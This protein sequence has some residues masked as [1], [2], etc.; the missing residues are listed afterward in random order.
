MKTTPLLITTI[1]IL[2]LAGGVWAFVATQ[3]N[4]ENTNGANVNTKEEDAMMEK[5]ENSNSSS[6]NAN[7]NTNTS[8]NTNQTSAAPAQYVNYS[9]SALAI[10]QS[11]EGGT[12]VL[13]FHANWCPVCRVL[14]PDITA[15]ISSL[16][17]GLTILKADYDTE[18]ALKSKYGVTYQHTFVQVD[19]N[20]NKRKLWSG[21]TDASDI[22]EQIL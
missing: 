20:G 12:T 1:V 22:A 6:T 11:T 7:A 13:Y 21:S 8:S 18:T 14:D 3:D 2:L 16:P 5:N 9:S 10:A 4:S 15:N 19:S 17:D